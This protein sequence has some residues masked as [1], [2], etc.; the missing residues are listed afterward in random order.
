MDPKKKFGQTLK[1][2][3]EKL[4]KSLLDIE[5]ETSIRLDYLKAIEEGTLDTLISATYAR[6]FTKQYANFLGLDGERLLREEKL[7]FLGSGKKPHFAYGISTVESRSS[8]MP[9]SRLWTYVLWAVLGVT[10]FSI[11]WYVSKHFGRF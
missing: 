2:Q 11:V 3:R 8:E 9:S 4:S 10:L 6:G 7:F 5:G 1:A